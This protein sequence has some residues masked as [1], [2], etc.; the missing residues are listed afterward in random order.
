M[1]LIDRYRL[2]FEVIGDSFNVIRIKEV[3][4]HY[5]D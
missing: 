1:S 5:G 4:N 2:I 3:S